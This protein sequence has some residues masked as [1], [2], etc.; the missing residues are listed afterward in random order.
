MVSQT[1]EPIALSTAIKNMIKS[2][3]SNSQQLKANNNDLI[4]GLNALKET[5]QQAFLGLNKTT[6]AAQRISPISREEG[7]NSPSA[8]LRNVHFTLL[9][10]N[11]LLTKY[12]QDIPF[13][14]SG[15]ARHETDIFRQSLLDQIKKL[16]IAAQLGGGGGGSGGILPGGKTEKAIVKEAETAG[17]DALEGGGAISTIELLKHSKSGFLKNLLRG[18]GKIPGIGLLKGAG[19]LAGGLGGAYLGYTSAAAIN[20][21]AQNQPFFGGKQG[22]VGSTAANYAGSI[23]G[24]ALLGASIAGPWGAV[25][26]GGVGLGAALYREFQPQIDDFL[27][28]TFTKIKGLTSGTIDWLNKHLPSWDDIKGKINAVGF[29]VGDYIGKF[30]KWATG[31][32]KGVNDWMNKNFPGLNNGLNTLQVDVETGNFKDILNNFIAGVNAINKGISNMSSSVDAWG[33]ANIPGWKSIIDQS[34]PAAI[35]ANA[36]TASNNPN[37]FTSQ[38][39]ADHQGVYAAVQAKTDENNKNLTEVLKGL[40]QW[41]MRTNTSSGSG[42]NG[43]QYSLDSYITGGGQAAGIIQAAYILNNRN[44]SLPNDNS[45]NGDGSYPFPGPSNAS[46]NSGPG[47]YPFPGPSNASNNSGPG[48]NPAKSVSPRIGPWDSPDQIIMPQGPWQPNIGKNYDYPSYMASEDLK[49]DT[50]KA[51]GKTLKVPDNQIQGILSAAARY[52]V[53]PKLIASVF[54]HESEF[55]PVPK[56]N[57]GSS[58]KGEGQFIDKT[59]QSY[60]KGNWRDPNVAADATAHYLHDLLVANKGDTQRALAGYDGLNPNNKYVLDELQQAGYSQKPAPVIAS[61]PP[62]PTP[63][64]IVDKRTKTPT[65]PTAIPSSAYNNQLTDASY[66]MGGNSSPPMSHDIPMAI[67][68]QGL[69]LVNHGSIVA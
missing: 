37:I 27:G 36:A 54:A 68:S 9:E 21:T 30:N 39:L 61:Q 49:N 69:I 24:D 15:T 4:A 8:L 28:K 42:F 25:I 64:Q 38:Q 41:F 17:E 22:I 31:F 18:A 33:A 3:N 46:N 58:A 7:I 34:T 56:L 52:G 19:R 55:N 47:S 5:I 6:K 57:P 43:A 44:L 29:D 60:V 12:L 67:T 23:G 66:K 48:Y 63:A 45:N 13:L 10:Q 65:P 40:L 53:D 50:F 26:G 32:D 2:V 11:K 35:A 14:T 62:A 51:W 16:V 1:D 20:P 59:A